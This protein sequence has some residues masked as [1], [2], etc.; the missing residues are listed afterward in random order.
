MIE[1][2]VRVYLPSERA[3]LGTVI[4][5]NADGKCWVKWD[6][7]DGHIGRV[8]RTRNAMSRE[9]GGYRDPGTLQEVSVVDRI[10]KI[11]P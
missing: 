9:F 1:I 5:V 4:A 7:G 2:G 8:G 10:A 6:E 11:E 3:L